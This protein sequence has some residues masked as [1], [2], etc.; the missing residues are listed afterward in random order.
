[1]ANE[2]TGEPA[3]TGA[4]EREDDWLLEPWAP[5]PWGSAALLGVAGLVVHFL[6][7]VP[8]PTPWRAAATG[9]VAVASLSLAVTFAPGR[10]KPSLIFSLLAGLVVA[11][12]AWRVESAGDRY[13]APEFWFAAGLLAVGL[14]LPLFQAGF[15]RLRWQTP[16]KVAHFHVWTD[17]ISLAG[18]AAFTGLSWALVWLLAAL[19]ELIQIDI[20]RELVAEEWFG[21][22]FAGAAFGA[23][24]GTLRNQLRILGT[25]QSVVLLVFSLLAVPLAAALAVFLVAVIFSGLDVLWEATRSATPVL[26]A[27][28][29][30]S[31]VLVNAVVR[32]ERADM[33]GSRIM[34]IAARILALGILPLTIFAAI[35]MG[36]RIAQHGLSPERIWSLIAI[37][38]GVAY[39]VGYF[40]AVL[41]GWRGEW[42][43]R[44]RRA[45]MHLAVATCVIAFILALPIVDFGAVSARN[46]VARLNS[47][48]VSVEDFDYAALRWDFGDAGRRALERLAKVGNGKVASLA[49]DTVAM[50]NRPYGTTSMNERRQISY[51]PDLSR[52]DEQTAD[53]IRAHLRDEIILC[54]EGCRVIN[55]GEVRQGRLIAVMTTSEYGTNPHL[56]LVKPKSAKAITQRIVDGALVHEHEE[57]GRA[58]SAD[59]VV[60]LRPFTGV[61]VFVNGEPASQPFK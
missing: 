60:E 56:L 31:F 52:F 9:F 45:N 37:A 19:F 25:L 27:I 55:L 59:G 18:A 34:R 33:S 8:D 1:M 13:A 46:Q 7:G 22:T 41:R 36:M 14:A 61:Q 51:K 35:S 42:D 3:L 23:A 48:K 43:E 6:S 54:R 2:D 30:G 15:H 12:L 28:A 10:A 44:L 57:L 11:G 39:G 20:L 21:L 53:A 5:R 38:V 24:L 50:R 26:L 47:G 32:D 58:P 16:Y 29:V 4:A 17:A 49:S 40:A